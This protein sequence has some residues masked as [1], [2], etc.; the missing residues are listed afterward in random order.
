MNRL[1]FNCEIEAKCHF[2]HL[3]SYPAMLVNNYGLSLVYSGKRSAPKLN[4]YC[5]I[6]M[7]M[8]SYSLSLLVILLLSQAA[9]TINFAR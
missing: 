9:L 8:L 7:P 6:D 3:R 1:W 5:L 4:Y 2:A